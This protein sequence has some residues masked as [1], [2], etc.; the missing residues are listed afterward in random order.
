MTKKITVDR[1]T[2]VNVPEGDGMM[3]D[4]GDW[5]RIRGAVERLGDPIVDWAGIWASI[6]VG[7]VLA[8]VAVVATIDTTK[9]AHKELLTALKVS[10]AFCA[11]FAV[12]FGIVGLREHR[13]HSVTSRGICKD[14]DEIATHLGHPGLGAIVARPR[15]GIKGW[16]LRFWRGD[17]PSEADTQEWK[18]EHDT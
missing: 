1:T 18:V 9:D 17:P 14:M 10:I 6:A 4:V 16:I 3:V 13:K 7:A 11:L 12:F 8:Q 15:I 2:N 5:S